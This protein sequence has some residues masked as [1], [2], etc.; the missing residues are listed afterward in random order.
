MMSQPAQTVWKQQLQRFDL[1]RWVFRRC[2]SLVSCIFFARFQ[3]SPSGNK[4]FFCGWFVGPNLPHIFLF[5]LIVTFWN[6]VCKHLFFPFQQKFRFSLYFIGIENIFAPTCE[7]SASVSDTK[8]TNS[9]ADTPWICPGRLL[10]FAFPDYRNR[11]SKKTETFSFSWKTF[12]HENGTVANPF[13]NDDEHMIANILRSR[14]VNQRN[15]N[16]VRKKET[17]P[18]FLG[19][20]E[21]HFFRK[22]VF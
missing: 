14:S 18:K 2:Y 5:L 19:R 13:F 20:K 12:V 11:I 1:L 21:W 15:F 17:I 8:S 4:V 6:L 9:I 22:E 10:P 3:F 16:S 7:T